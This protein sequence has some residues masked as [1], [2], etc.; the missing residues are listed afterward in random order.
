MHALL[1]FPFFS[2]MMQLS[3]VFLFVFCLYVGKCSGIIPAANPPHPPP[4]PPPPL[5]TFTIKVIF[6]L[7]TNKLK[8]ITITF[9]KFIFLPQ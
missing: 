7:K 2:Y 8:S 4:P 5:I 9:S 3:F 1:C 6:I